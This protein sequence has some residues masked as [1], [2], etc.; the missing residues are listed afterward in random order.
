MAYINLTTAR[1]ANAM[2]GAQDFLTSMVSSVLGWNQVRR[3]RDALNKLSDH[4]LEDI[5]LARGDIESVA[6]KGHR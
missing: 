2:A 4:E 3:T 6:L 1:S 5:G